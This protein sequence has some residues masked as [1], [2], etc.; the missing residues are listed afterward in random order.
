VKKPIRALVV[1]HIEAWAHIF[2]EAT[3]RAG[4]S[5]VVI[6]QDLQ[7]VK[8]ALRN[9]RFDIAIL[10]VGLDPD[11]DL[12][13]DGIRVLEAIRAIDGGSTKCV[14]VTGWQG[15]DR[16]DLQ[17]AAQQKFGVDWAYMKEKYEPNKVIPK[18]TELLDQAGKERLP[19]ATPMANLSASVEPIY[20]EYQLLDTLSPW[21]GVQTLYSLASQ[22]LGSASPIIAMYP[23]RPME[24]GS[25]GIW[26][27][28]Y[29][30][31]ALAT[32]VAVSL[33]PVDDDNHVPV[34]LGHLIEVGMISDLE[35]VQQS[36]VQG[37]LWVLSD[38]DRGNFPR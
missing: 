29:W 28:L 26:V 25:D 19:Q 16:M 21:G 9:A 35:Q 22:L 14:L 17:A 34:K 24:M 3:R 31:R 6:C 1:E 38:L 20:F 13:S 37:K 4:A 8:D 18:L 32:A 30:S 5:E 27:G 11:D 10:E 23:A 33:G 36:N 12:N 15:G 7:M 2:A